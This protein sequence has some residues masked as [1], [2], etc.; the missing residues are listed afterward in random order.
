MEETNYYRESLPQDKAGLAPQTNARMEKDQPD[1]QRSEESN[2]ASLNQDIA[3]TDIDQTPTE[4]RG[5]KSYLAQLKVFDKKVMRYPNRMTGM[6]LRPLIFL[7][8]PVIS[9]SGFCYG[10]NLIWFN[11]LN[12]TTSLILSEDPYNFSS[13][14]VGLCYFSPLIGVTIG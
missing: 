12:G 9:Y 10:S 7:S 11:V 5:T 6:F 13:S 3:L 4:E 1:E 2:L 8:F 14:M